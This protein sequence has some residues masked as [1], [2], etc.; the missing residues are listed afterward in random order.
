MNENFSFETDSG[1][2]TE[3][4]FAIEV[5][6]GVELKDRTSCRRVRTSRRQRT[7]KSGLQTADQCALTS[8]D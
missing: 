5:F 7:N 3:G 1:G 4:R 2:V 6:Y 8:A